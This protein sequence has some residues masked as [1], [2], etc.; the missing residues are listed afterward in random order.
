M[1]ITDARRVRAFPRT[2][3]ALWHRRATRMGPHRVLSFDISS[4]A[5]DTSLQ[6]QKFGYHTSYYSQLHH[7]SFIPWIVNFLDNN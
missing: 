4:G 7:L 3:M 6:T 1:E 2:L 5:V